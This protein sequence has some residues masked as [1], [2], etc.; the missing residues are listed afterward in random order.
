MTNDLSSSDDE[1]RTL[2]WVADYQFGPGAGEALFGDTEALELTRSTSGRPRQVR[3]E[4]GHVVT[5]STD[6]RFT[7]GLA[8]GRRL[9]ESLQY[10]SYRVVV[11]DESAPYVRDGR[12]VFAKFV[13]E[14][15]PD[16]RPG[17]EV[18]VVHHEGDLL[19]VGRAEL[20]AGDMRDFETGV[21]VAIRDGASEAL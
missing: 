1:F 8:G 19:G 10:P 9:H 20:P 6:G 13:R 15:D 7:L 3:A 12:N 14:V 18:V 16:I 4:D 11:G 2:A 5:Y 17:D 21:A